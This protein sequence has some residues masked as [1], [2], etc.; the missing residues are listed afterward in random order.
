MSQDFCGQFSF[1]KKPPEP[2]VASG[3]GIDL[4]TDTA[5]GH[6]SVHTKNVTTMQKEFSVSFTAGTVKTG[7]PGQ[8]SWDITQRTGKL[9]H[10]IRGR[11]VM[12][13]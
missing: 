12:T 4:D 3:K 11:I 8:N 7:R 1:K 6:R 5:H 9:E 13:E 10:D 2:F